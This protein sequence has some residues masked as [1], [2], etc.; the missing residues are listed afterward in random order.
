MGLGAMLGNL[1]GQH[2]FDNTT[3]VDALRVLDNIDFG[4]SF[5]GESSLTGLGGTFALPAPFDGDGS[6]DDGL[7]IKAAVDSSVLPP[8]GSKS[9]DVLCALLHEY[10]EATAADDTVSSELSI[11]GNIK[12]SADDDSTKAVD[13]VEFGLKFEAGDFSYPILKDEE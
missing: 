2:G 12:L 3:F 11:A 10:F 8:K 4:I 1:V 7:S 6:M 9:C 13:G 5:S